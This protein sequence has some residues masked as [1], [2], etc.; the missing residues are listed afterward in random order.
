MHLYLIKIVCLGR[1][2][3]EVRFDKSSCDAVVHTMARYPQ[4]CV[5]VARQI[6]GAA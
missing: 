3:Y 6:G 4:Q 5:I 1:A 2:Y